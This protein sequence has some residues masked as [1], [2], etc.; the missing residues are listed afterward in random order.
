MLLR[1]VCITQEIMK[2]DWFRTSVQNKCATQAGVQSK[3]RTWE[4]GLQIPCSSRRGV[5]NASFHPPVTT[6]PCISQI[7][8][9]VED[10]NRQCLHHHAEKI[11]SH[12]TSQSGISQFDRTP[13]IIVCCEAPLF[14]YFHVGDDIQ[15]TYSM[16]A[17]MEDWRTCYMMKYTHMSSRLRRVVC[18]RDLSQCASR[19]CR[20]I[21][22]PDKSTHFIC[23]CTTF[24]VS[25]VNLEG[26]ESARCKWAIMDERDRLNCH[27]FQQ[28]H[29]ILITAAVILLRLRKKRFCSYWYNVVAIAT[30]PL[31]NVVE[32]RFLSWPCS[33]R[34]NCTDTSCKHKAGDPL[35]LMDLSVD[36]M[37]TREEDSICSRG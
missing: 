21:A 5:A 9:L 33:C 10:A 25:R 19:W 2:S 11:V 34:M 27:G 26:K 20:W 7:R 16:H 18:V 29:L 6:I 32:A 1:E 35:A 31:S 28:N 15:N 4:H 8:I 22:A 12:V 14:H 37:L 24:A 3:M 23:L 17:N 36:I 13:I 30:M